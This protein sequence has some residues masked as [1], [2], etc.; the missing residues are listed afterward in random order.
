MEAMQAV[1]GLPLAEHAQEQ[2]SITVAERASRAR[3]GQD[4]VM[5]HS[6]EEVREPAPEVAWP[7]EWTEQRQPLRAAFWGTSRVT[8]RGGLSWR[9]LAGLE[10]APVHCV[11][12]VGPIQRGSRQHQALT[13]KACK[14]EMKQPLPQDTLCT[15]Q[16]RRG[17]R[18]GRRPAHGRP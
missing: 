10:R 11:K 17:G 15:P 6:T 3:G 12:E 7:L 18:G 4:A 5:G 14:E 9:C 2:S 16:T 8:V 13:P 1:W